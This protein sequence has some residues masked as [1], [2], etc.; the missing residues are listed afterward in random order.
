MAFD[1]EVA[2]RGR[3]AL[4]DRPQLLERRMF[5]GVAFMVRCHAPTRRRK[6]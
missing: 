2:N 6:S 5:G 1:V 3:R 4:A